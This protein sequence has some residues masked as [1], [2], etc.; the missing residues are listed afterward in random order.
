MARKFGVR[1]GKY[2]GDVYMRVVR[3][4]LPET[5]FRE[6]NEKFG[7]HH[8][9]AAI[10]FG[11]FNFLTE[12]FPQERDRIRRELEQELGGKVE[13]LLGKARAVKCRS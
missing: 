13:E 6:I 10:R 5:L 12:G 11:M 7:Q 8:F 1:P 4:R 2:W 9:S 3:I